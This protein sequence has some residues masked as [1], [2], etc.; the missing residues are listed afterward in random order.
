MRLWS[1]LLVALAVVCGL[2]A[3]ASAEPGLR[4]AISMGSINHGG[5][6]EDLSANG[7]LEVVQGTGA[8]WV[9]IWMRWDKAQPLP[10][11]S[12]PMSGLDSTRNDAPGCGTGCGFRYI[13]SVDAQIAAARAAGLNVVLVMWH[14]PRWANGTEGM[15]EDWGRN[16][17]GTATT[18][19]EQ[20]KPM[21]F[22]VPVGH[23]GP[24]DYYGR[25]LDW[26]IGRYAGYGHSLALEIMNEPNGQLWPQQGLSAPGLPYGQGPVVIDDYVAEMMETARTVS[27]ARGDPV[28]LL[29][30]SLSDS[31][32]ENTRLMTNIET[33]VPATLDALEARDFG[34]AGNFAWSHHNYEDVERNIASPTRAEQVR[35]DL[36]GRWPGMGGPADPKLWL[37]EGGARLGQGQAVDLASQAELVR[38]NWDR[39]QAAPGIQMWTNYLL[40]GDA[41][42]NSGLHQARHR[43]GRPRPVLN[44]FTAFPAYL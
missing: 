20:L 42:T 34:T 19:V 43:A 16:D 23:L 1:V 7:N 38:L 29:G 37:T 5:D 30:P 2:A 11:S 25:W 14:F 40:F 21:E 13:Q 17:R 33:A 18:P 27:A 26:L 36:V 15:P 8:R 41:T 35:A 3:T 39:M 6:T 10:P 44:V 24:D 12:V 22:R 4:K 28:L 9:R 31:V 32:G